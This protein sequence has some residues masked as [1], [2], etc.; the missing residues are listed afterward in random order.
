MFRKFVAATSILVAQIAL[1]SIA[2]AHAPSGAI[3]TTV[4]D[5]SEV[6]YNHY[7]SKD[8]VYLDGGPGPGAPQ[9]AAGL[10]DGTYVFQVTDP[11][12]RVLLSTDPARCRRFVVTAGIITSVVPSACQ[13]VT[14]VDIDHGAT[15]VQLMPYDD[16]PNP[17]GVYK[18][19]VT[20]VEDFLLGCEALGVSNGLDVVD[21]GRASGNQHGFIP[22]HCKTD[23]YKVKDV[24]IVEI[25]TRFY[26]SQTGRILDNHKVTWIDT[27]GASNV[28]Y[29]YYSARLDVN[30]EAHVEGVEPGTHRIVIENQPLYHVDRV[31]ANGGTVY[32]A[33][34]VDVHIP[35]LNKALTVYVDAYVSS[36]GVL[37]VTPVTDKG[38]IL[39]AVRPNPVRGD[40][41]KLAFALSSS[42]KAQLELVNISGRE[43]ASREVGGLGAGRHTVDIAAGQKLAPGVYMVR[44]TQGSNNLIQRVA[45]IQ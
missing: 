15:T 29:S 30:H 25:D 43:V 7:P 27:Q 19:W 5:G 35:N 24:P 18:V 41:L 31:V 23:N 33:Q 21:A 32:G 39:E 28:K 13:H 26:D 9:H 2:A 42:A 6:N 12:G 40:R 45:V 11:S 14:G 16:T 8:S 10:D 20:R 1:V 4:S 17:G 44:L 36:V 22:A 34:T 3:F 38:F 37:G